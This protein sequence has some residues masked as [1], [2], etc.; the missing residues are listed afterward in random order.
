MGELL[1]V[2]VW[3]DEKF[4]VNK[5]EEVKIKLTK[6]RFLAENRI[7]KLEKYKRKFETKT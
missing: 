7:E 1:C 5:I 4:E 2:F 3:E 6:V